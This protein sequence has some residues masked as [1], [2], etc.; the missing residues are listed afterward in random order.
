MDKYSDSLREIADMLDE[1]FNSKILK[2]IIDRLLKF[3]AELVRYEMTY[4]R[5]VK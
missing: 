3:V 5:E 2:I 4:F 1:E